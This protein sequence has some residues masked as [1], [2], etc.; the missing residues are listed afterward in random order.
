MMVTKHDL[1]ILVID[2]MT[3]MRHLIKLQLVDAGFI[4]IVE[5]NDGATALPMIIAAKKEGKAFDLIL[6][7][8]NMPE[9]SGIDLLKILRKTPGLEKL[10]F[11]MITMEA[12]QLNVEVA[13]KKGV[14]EFLVKPFTGLMLRNKINKIFKYQND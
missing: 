11:L 5:A 6:S 7:D 10:P 1:K 3:S 4:N 2:D 13:I 12:E 14:T 9:M 8:W